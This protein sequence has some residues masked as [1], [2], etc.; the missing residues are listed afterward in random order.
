MAKKKRDTVKDMLVVKGTKTGKIVVD[1]KELEVK[2]RGLTWQEF[3]ACVEETFN[4]KKV[5]HIP[6]LVSKV[7]DRVIVS[8]GGVPWKDV[9]KSVRFEVG[10]QLEKFLPDLGAL[11]KNLER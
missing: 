3:N 7:Q 5:L 10:I 11:K 1:G 9:K 6:T 2:Y 8:I 4:E